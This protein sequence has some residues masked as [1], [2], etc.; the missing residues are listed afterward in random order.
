VVHQCIYLLFLLL[1]CWC[2]RFIFLGG[3]IQPSHIVVSP[4]L[5]VCADETTVGFGV[6]D[7]DERVCVPAF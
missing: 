3:C 6:W 7:F 4:T 1:T 5:F 2:P